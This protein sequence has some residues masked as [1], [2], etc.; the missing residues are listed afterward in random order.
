MRAAL[1]YLL[2][3]AAYV[4]K[5]ADST[6]GIFSFISD[7]FENCPLLDHLKGC[8]C[9]PDCNTRSKI[10]CIVTTSTSTTTTTTSTTTTPPSTTNRTAPGARR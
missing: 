10:C 4:I 7:I 2:V 9:D 3:M 8:C 1:L 6:P 5:E